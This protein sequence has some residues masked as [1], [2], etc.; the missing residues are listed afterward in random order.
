[1]RAENRQRQRVTYIFA[2]IISQTT[3]IRHIQELTKP[4]NYQK[5]TY[6]KVSKINVITKINKII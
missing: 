1:M 5:K 3:V 4:K 6:F 2:N